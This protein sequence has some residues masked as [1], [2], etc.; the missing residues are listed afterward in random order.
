[1]LVHKIRQNETRVISFQG[2]APNAL[3]EEMLQN[4]SEVKVIMQM[5]RACFECSYLVCKNVRLGRSA[6]GSARYAHGVEPCSRPVWRVR[7]QILFFLLFSLVDGRD[8]QCFFA[9][10]RGRM[11]S[12]EL[13]P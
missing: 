8:F 13:Q 2:S 10:C 1:M 7:A 11:L 5:C 3:R 6:C 4:V 12:A 9:V